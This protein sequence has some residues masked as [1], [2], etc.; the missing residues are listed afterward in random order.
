MVKTAIERA[1]SVFQWFNVKSNVSI[2]IRCGV[3]STTEERT[4]VRS[5]DGKE[6]VMDTDKILEEY[7]N[8]DDGKRLSLF[9]AYR[10]LREQ[11]STME[12]ESVHD[13]FAIFEFSWSRKR[14]IPHAA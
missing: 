4:S 2:M 14:H 9:L 8:G 11:F 10:E 12:Q 13:D 6:I 7:Q 5:T 1:D 3:S